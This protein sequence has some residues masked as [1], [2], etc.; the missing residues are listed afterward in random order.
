MFLQAVTAEWP[1][2]EVLAAI[3]AATDSVATDSVACG[4]AQLSADIPTRAVQPSI[5]DFVAAV[6]AAPVVLGS[7]FALILTGTAASAI[8]ARVTV[9]ATPIFGVALIPTGGGIRAHTTRISN[10]RLDWRTR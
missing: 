4:P 6:L 7:E 2:T 8:L 5:E 1:P 3:A 9:T 10:T